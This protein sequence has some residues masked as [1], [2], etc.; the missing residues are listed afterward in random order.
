LQNIETI[1]EKKV[2]IDKPKMYKVYLINDDYTT[3]N[4]VIDILIDI[5]LKPRSSAVL[6]MYTIHNE[7]KGLCG[8]YT[9]EIA[10]TKIQQVRIMAS[11]YNFPLIATMESE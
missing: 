11:N 8:V 6:I 2:K 7:G 9:H 4:F 1:N 5:F 3:M 10:K